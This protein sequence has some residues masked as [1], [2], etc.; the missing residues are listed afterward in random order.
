MCG[1]STSMSSSAAAVATCGVAVVSE[2][3]VGMASTAETVLGGD[4]TTDITAGGDTAGL[5]DVKGG[6]GELLVHISGAG[7][8]VLTLAGVDCTVAWACPGAA[9]TSG[10]APLGSAAAGAPDAAASCGAAGGAGMT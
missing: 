5:D 4:E 9:T 7:V 10:A 6:V 8:G 2:A 3:G 1:M